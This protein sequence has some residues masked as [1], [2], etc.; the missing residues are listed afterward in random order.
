MPDAGETATAAAT[1][2]VA[3]LND[4]G[5]ATITGNAV[6]DQQLTASLVDEDGTSNLSYQWKRTSNGQA[7]NI[8]GNS[9]T[10]TLTQSEVG[11]TITVVISYTDVIANAGATATSAATGAVAN[12]NDAPGGAVT[13]TGNA[14]EDQVLKATNNLSDED[15]MPA[16]N[17]FASVSYTHL[18]LPTI[19]LV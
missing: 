11:S 5:V 6:E 18:T 12:V 3:N 16:A 14:V 9:A 15:G 1:G 19:L 10:Y 17:T 4:V 8:G 7:T 2:V 13:I